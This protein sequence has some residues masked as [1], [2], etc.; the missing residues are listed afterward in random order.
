MSR[1]AVVGHPVSTQFV[2]VEVRVGVATSDRLLRP[3]TVAAAVAFREVNPGAR[4]VGG[5]TLVVAERSRGVDFPD[6]YILLS[7]S[8]TFVA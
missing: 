5:G 6:A 3:A 1:L 4:L 2:R 7:A 8:R